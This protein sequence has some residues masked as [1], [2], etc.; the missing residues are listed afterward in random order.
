M[1]TRT[2]YVIIKSKKI[3]TPRCV[4]LAIGI[5]G[6]VLCVV[7]VEKNGG[8]ECGGARGGLLFYVPHPHPPSTSFIVLAHGRD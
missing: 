2:M 7:C 4:A 1:A 5:F 8:V 6:V 3:R